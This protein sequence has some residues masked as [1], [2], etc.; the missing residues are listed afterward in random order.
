MGRRPKQTLLQRRHIDG[1][2][3]HGKMLDI[4][5]YQ[6]NSSQNCKE[7]LSHIGHNEFNQKVYKLKVLQMVWSKGDTPKLLKKMHI[8]KSTIENN[9]KFLKN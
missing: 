3:A 8:C 1:Q 4:A 7:M 6:K 9:I 2:Q 5:N